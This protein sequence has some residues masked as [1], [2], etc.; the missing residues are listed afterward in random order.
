MYRRRITYHKTGEIKRFA[1]EIYTACLS[2][3]EYG[4]ALDL[5]V[6]YIKYL[7]EQQVEEERLKNLSKNLLYNY[8]MEIE[9]L[10]GQNDRVRDKYF[11]DIAK[12]RRVDDFREVMQGIFTDLRAR[13][14]DF[15][16][17]TAV[18]LS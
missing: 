17:S 14:A 5:Y 4:K 1:Y 3:K 16:L 7:C 18:S 9:K 12:T 11:R 13:R 8:L 10:S 15:P 6:D 2:S